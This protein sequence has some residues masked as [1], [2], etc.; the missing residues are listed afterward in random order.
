MEPK[1]GQYWRDRK[2]RIYRTHYI[3]MF[4]EVNPLGPEGWLPSTS[5]GIVVWKEGVE[6][7]D[8]TI[9]SDAE[10]AHLQKMEKSVWKDDPTQA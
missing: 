10:V 9:L 5:Y 4:L 6:D 8:I 1:I 2:Q 7:G 3:G